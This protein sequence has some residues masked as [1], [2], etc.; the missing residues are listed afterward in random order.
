MDR[1][2]KRVALAFPPLASPTYVPLGLASLAAVVQRDPSCRLTLHD[3]NLDAHLARGPGRDGDLVAFLRGERGDFYDEPQY[4]AHR[5]SWQ[6]LTAALEGT[7]A[8]A[9]RYATLGEAEP[10]LVELLEGQCAALLADDPELVGLSVL[11]PSQLLPA[12]ALAR[13]LKQR[14]GARVVLGGAT[15]SAVHADEILICCP[16]VDGV[17]CGEGEEAMMQLCAGGW[18]QVPGLLYRADGR[19]LRRN[20]QGRTESLRALPAPDFSALPL[21]SYLNPAPVLPVLFSRGCRWRRCR[22]CAHNVSFAGYRRK[23]IAAFVDELEL[24]EARHGARHFYLADQYLEAADLDG[25]AGE[26]ARRDLALAFHAMGRPDAAHTPELLERAAAGGCRWIS[27]GVES[28]SQRL[29]D[30]ARK[31]IDLGE[32]R[33]VLRDAQRAKISNLVMLIFGLPTST[34]EDLQQT[35]RL[36]EEIYPLVDALTA[37]SF[38]LFSGTHFG[39]NAS[40]YGLQ[41][42]GAQELLR[43]GDRSLRSHRLRFMQRDSAGGLAPPRGPLEVAAWE[44]RRRWLGP[45]PIFD[46]LGAEHYLLHADRRARREVS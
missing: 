45:L 36:I 33:R 25:L 43:A 30:L 18:E 24:H 3:L 46:R 10:G 12:L 40:R 2:L 11:F 22:F 34:D 35:L 16:Q 8:G 6:T 32:A 38:V 4:D 31:G 13:L 7:L 19:S 39:R 20:R 37:S 17:V 42:L 21:A 1:T 29:L 28:G 44:E 27:W 5:A 26:L 14:G 9:A 15:M 41:T 23:P